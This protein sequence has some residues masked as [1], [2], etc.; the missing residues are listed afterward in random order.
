MN[1]LIAALAYLA[2]L[3]QRRSRTSPRS[4]SKR[5]MVRMEQ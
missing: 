1:Q 4:A 5:Y 3:G 2:A